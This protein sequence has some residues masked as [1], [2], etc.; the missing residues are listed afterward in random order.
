M[1]LM[2]ILVVEDEPLIRLFVVDILEDAGFVVVEATSAAEAMAQL[3]S[4]SLPFDAAIID[5]GLPDKRGDDLAKELRGARKDLPI[6]IA[7]GHDQTVIAERFGD[8]G[9]VRVLGKPYYGDM[10]LAAMGAMGVVAD[11]AE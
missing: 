3:G 2:R 4:G 8:D 5:V 1:S 10:L 11:K 9:F 6:V 7:T